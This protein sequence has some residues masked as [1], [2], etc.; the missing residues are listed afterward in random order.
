MLDDK[1]EDEADDRLRAEADRLNTPEP[2]PEP[3][4]KPEPEPE[5]EPNPEP[6]RC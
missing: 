5:P 3:K 1:P 4:P 2:K 6:L